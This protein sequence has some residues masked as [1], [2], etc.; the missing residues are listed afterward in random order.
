MS[1]ISRFF[2]RNEKETQ[3]KALVANPDIEKPLSLQ[4]LFS[5]K[6]EFSDAELTKALRSF[7]R[8]MAS[9]TCERDESID[10]E[11]CLF[12]LVGWDKHVIRMI[13]FNQ[14][15]PSEPLERCIAPSHYP[16]EL[17]EKARNHKSHVI[18]YYAGYEPAPLEQYVALATLAGVL[19]KFGAIVVLN[20]TAHTSFPAAA[21]AEDTRDK[22]NRLRVIPLLLLYCGFVKYEIEGVEG[23]WM[24]THG[25]H[26]LGMPDLAALAK[27]HHQGQLYFD[28]FSNIFHYLL[29]SGAV[30]GA[31][32]TMQVDE[33]VFIRLREPKEGEYF[34]ESDGQLYVAELITEEQINR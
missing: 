24:R 1:L 27:G 3:R 16:Q 8:S 26:L 32:H 22:M 6:L 18:L 19:S 10:K 21:L 30:L 28:M 34:L 17:K 14:S 15:M 11:G 31:G 12:A 13:G 20:E 4:L 25:A 7:H 9:A 29:D 33:D 5:K 23:V 2:G